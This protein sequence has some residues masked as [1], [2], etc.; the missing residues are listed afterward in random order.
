M[1]HSIFKTIAQHA[2]VFLHREKI[3]Q[4]PNLREIESFEN[5]AT[6]SSNQ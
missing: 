6:T 1:L 3:T 2:N 5:E 4:E